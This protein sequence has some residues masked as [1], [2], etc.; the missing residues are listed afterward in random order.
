MP[1]KGFE[2]VVV[3]EVGEIQKSGNYSN[4]IFLYLNRFGDHVEVLI[5]CKPS[6]FQPVCENNARESNQMQ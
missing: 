1:N 6:K 3:Y 2:F 5:L 4:Y